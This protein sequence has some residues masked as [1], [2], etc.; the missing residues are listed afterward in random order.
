MELLGVGIFWIIVIALFF[1][2]DIK[3]F[4]VDIIKAI[5]EK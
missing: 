2:E 1:I 5:K 4:I 3:E